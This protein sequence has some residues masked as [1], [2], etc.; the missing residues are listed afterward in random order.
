M[1]G[2]NYRNRSRVAALLLGTAV[3]GVPSMAFAQESGAA[4][5]E[6]ASGSGLGEII[7]TARKREE[8]LQTTPI[9]IS[10]VSAAQL[11]AQGVT[12][13]MDLQ[14]STPNLT[15]KNI[16]SN[17]GVA[18]NAAVYIRGIG[19]SDFAPGV[20]PGGG[21]HRGRP[22]ARERPRLSS[23][24]G[25]DRRTGTH[26]ARSRAD[27]HRRVSRVARARPWPRA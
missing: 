9:S 20:D 22:R 12:S 18:S 27:L 6:A 25:H 5:P 4:N 23:G 3:L 26:A 2:M 15:F 16:P 17:S 7:V 13:V 19:Q 1:V 8:S 21:A 10:A 24:A 11:D 14:D